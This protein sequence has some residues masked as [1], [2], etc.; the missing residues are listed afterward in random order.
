MTAT[1]ADLPP[2]QLET[3]PRGTRRIDVREPVEFTG[4]LGHL[5]D[6]ELVPLATLER[7]VAD[8]PRDTPLLLICRSGARSVRAAAALSALGFTRLY[9]LAGGMVAVR[10][11]AVLP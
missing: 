1:H 9:N 10:A 2:D 7:T 3:L 5:P 11:A 4:P 8:W 6:A